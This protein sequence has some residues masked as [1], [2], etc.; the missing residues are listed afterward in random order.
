PSR[1]DVAEVLGAASRAADLTRQ[2]LVFSRKQVVEP[3][4]LDPAEVVRGIERMLTRLM[5]EDITIVTSLAPEAGQVRVDR[6]Q[7]EQVIVNLAANARDAMPTGGS[8]ALSTERVVVLAHD[9][10]HA[11]IAPGT[12]VRLSASDS[13]IGMTPE[14]RSRVFEPFFTTKERGRGTGL[15][16]ALVYSIVQQAGG[17]LRVDSAP[18]AG[19][20]FEVYLP[21]VAREVAPAPR[22]RPTNELTGGAERLLLVED[23]PAVRTVTQQ[24]L[25]RHG[26][27]VST[28]AGGHE[29]LAILAAA[30]DAYALVI[31]DVVM[32]GMRGRELAERIRRLSATLPVLFVSG[33]ADDEA[34]LEELEP[35][36]A[37]FLAKP[38][39][40]AALL[41][42][43]R[44]AL[45]GAPTQV[46]QAVA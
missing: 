35:I 6:G 4:V 40:I 17:G 26:Y 12:Y 45:D 2:I 38:F 8:F 9:A 1:R 10:R 11:G 5:R 33:Y 39:T 7:L 32:P 13:G 37:S 30:D 15:G 36:G 42:K 22:D 14:V 28:A 3:Q 21:L 20:T 27:R 23:D 19:T 18:G 31:T 46:P 34:L 24:M 25:E 44:D 29:A 16:L 41:R 43:V